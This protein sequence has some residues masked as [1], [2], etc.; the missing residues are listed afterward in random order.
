M[1]RNVNQRTQQLDILKNIKI[2]VWRRQCKIR[3]RQKSFELR[4]P[5]LKQ[6]SN[7]WHRLR[8]VDICLR[9]ASVLDVGNPPVKNLRTS[10]RFLDTVDQWRADG[11]LEGGADGVLDDGRVRLGATGLIERDKAQVVG[12]AIGRRDL[13]EGVDISDARDEV[14]DEWSELGGTFDLLGLELGDVSEEVAD[15]L[16]DFWKDV[17]VVVRVVDG[18][19]TTTLLLLLTTT[20]TIIVVTHSA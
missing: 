12:L 16:R 18:I 20:H 2:N 15:F 5:L 14:G 11:D 8:V 4:R 7:V 9:L 10:V 1:S 13:D 6:L 19:S 17:C 3:T